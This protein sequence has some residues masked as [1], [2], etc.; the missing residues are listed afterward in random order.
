[1]NVD[2]EGKNGDRAVGVKG[3]KISVVSLKYRVNRRT[4]YG[5]KHIHFWLKDA[6]EVA[7]MY[8]D[9]ANGSIEAARLVRNFIPTEDRTGLENALCSVRCVVRTWLITNVV[10]CVT[11]GEKWR[12]V[13]PR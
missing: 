3:L 12:Y 7:R 10:G 13:S 6:R 11:E 5:W 2:F 1:M 4:M 8:I 9:H